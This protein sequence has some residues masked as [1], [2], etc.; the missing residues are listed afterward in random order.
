MM[1]CDDEDCF[2]ERLRH[3]YHTE[4]ESF[5]LLTTVVPTKQLED[6]RNVL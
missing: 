4:Q 3:M 2:D 1:M 6:T 5:C